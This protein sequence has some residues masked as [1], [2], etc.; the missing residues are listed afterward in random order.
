MQRLNEEFFPV[1]MTVGI[2]SGGSDPLAIGGDESDVAEK[3]PECRANGW[4][5]ELR[6]PNAQWY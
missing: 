5:A 2:L 3:S 6:V 4:Q 1:P